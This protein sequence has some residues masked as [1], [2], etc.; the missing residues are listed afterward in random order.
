M[1][2]LIRVFSFVCVGSF[3]LACLPARAQDASKL[4]V[5][6]G[7]S[8]L[9]VDTNGADF[10]SLGITSRQSANG[11]EGSVSSRVYKWLAAEADFSGY[12]KAYDFSSVGFGTVDVRDYGFLGG[13]RVNLGPAFIHG[14]VGADHLTGSAM[15]TSESQDSFAAAFG[16]GL[17][18]PVAPRFAIR[19]SAD[20]VLTRHNI[21]KI[22]E[23]AL[24][25]Y[26]QNNFRA[27]VG[28]VFRF[29]ASRGTVSRVSREP[30]SVASGNEEAPLLGVAGYERSDGF[31]VLSVRALSAAAAAGI[32]P[33]DVVMS[34][35][36]RPVQSSR[37]IEAA[38]AMS[39]TGIVK[40]MYFRS[41]VLQME[42]DVKV[43]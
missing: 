30:E 19:A 15:G 33:G 9:N 37:D 35:D 7:Y 27:S 36:A 42:A 8:Y 26:T 13:P 11:W 21:F 20:Y 29:G 17:Q 39:Q 2:K 32:K 18:I 28:I 22:V 3:F 16:G 43:R 40:V 31:F 4:D 23:P 12:Y 10:Q 41:G 25:N 5:F 1:N 38:C 6:V 14:L 34:I 24:P